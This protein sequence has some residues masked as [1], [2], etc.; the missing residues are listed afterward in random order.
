MLPSHQVVVLVVVICTVVVG[1]S[2]VSNSVDLFTIVSGMVWVV[3]VSVATI[4]IG[5]THRQL[6]ALD[7]TNDEYCDISE[8]E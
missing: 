7:S 6:Q 1:P 5:S 2:T 3:V 8:L 4:P